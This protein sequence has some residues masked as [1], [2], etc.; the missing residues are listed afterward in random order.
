MARTLAQFT[1]TP[2][3]QGDYTLHLEDEDGETIE[4]TAGYEQLD[5]IVEAIEEQ[6]D[7]DE[8]DALGVDT[9]EDEAEPEE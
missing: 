9:D 1:I 4:F 7:T 6:L 2:D 8:E 5:L 3:A